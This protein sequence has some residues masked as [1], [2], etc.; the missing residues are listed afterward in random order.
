MR[1]RLGPWR[2]LDVLVVA[3]PAAVLADV[4]GL[5]APVLFVLSALA[6]IP[7]AG[8]VGRS[9]EV[10]AERVGGSKGALL[11]ATFGNV[12]ELLIAALLVVNGEI[13]VL[14]AS[15]TGSIIGNLLLLLGVSMVVAAHDKSEVPIT[16]TSRVQ[17][18]MLFLAMGILLLPTVFS[19]RPESSTARL[20]EV[21][22][23]VALILFAVYALSMLF[24]LRT[25]R[26]QFQEDGE[27]SGGEG[28]DGRGS[29]G[30]GA[31]VEEEQAGGKEQAGEAA[32]DGRPTWSVKGAVVV[33]A[34]ATALVAVAAEMVAGSV[35][36]AGSALGL[37]SG[38]IG[39]VIL[40]LV[41]NAAEQF[42]ALGLAAKDRLGVASEIAVGASMQLAM[43]VV[44]ILVLLGLVTGNPF[45][46]AF[47]PLEL[48]A[49]IIGT[50][51]TR[52]LLDDGK[53]NWLEGVMLLGLYLAF[54]GAVFFADLSG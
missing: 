3:L 47:S 5:G 37:H 27:G 42:S 33:L 1:T 18:T 21:S 6:V 53:A 35:E 23:L 30:D 45:D 41:G 54:A 50:L 13:P 2:V 29:G 17:A 49:L 48:S 52:H 36:E 38:F 43:F 40:P 11:N 32:E 24:M 34:V 44:P 10:L 26:H 39:F 16:V 19:F 9:T 28:S 12:A 20:D 7:L 22:G 31:G 51:L 14:K 25:N 46:L 4:V 8:L 15:I